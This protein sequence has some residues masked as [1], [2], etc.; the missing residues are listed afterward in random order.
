MSFP[1]I[2]AESLVCEYDGPMNANLEAQYRVAI[3]MTHDAARRQDLGMAKFAVGILVGI[4]ASALPEDDS[5][6]LFNACADVANCNHL[7]QVLDCAAMLNRRS[8]D[9]F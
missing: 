7:E 3:D 4:V 1:R 8:S 5:R 2:V 6:A 9:L